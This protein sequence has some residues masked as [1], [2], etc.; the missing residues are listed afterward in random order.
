MSTQTKSITQDAGAAPAR[1]T[2][3]DVHPAIRERRPLDYWSRLFLV[4]GEADGDWSLEARTWG[5]P[6]EPL[7]H[8]WNVRAA[9][10]ARQLDPRVPVPP[11]APSR[12]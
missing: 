7:V 11:R 10:A 6:P 3:P 12:G 5:N 9:L 2:R 4:R 1:S 8:D